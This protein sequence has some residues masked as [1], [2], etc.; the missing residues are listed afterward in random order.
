MSIWMGFFVCFVGADAMRMGN[1]I[2]NFWEWLILV[3]C[4]ILFYEHHL[5]NPFVFIL[6]IHIKAQYLLLQLAVSSFTLKNPDDWS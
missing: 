6:G 2:T 5:H 3:Y 4:L 1:V